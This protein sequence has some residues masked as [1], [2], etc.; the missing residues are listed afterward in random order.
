MTA[1]IGQ[2]DHQQFSTIADFGGDHV[3]ALM[4]GMATDADYE[5]QGGEQQRMKL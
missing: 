3:I 2:I 1:T 4:G 5:Q